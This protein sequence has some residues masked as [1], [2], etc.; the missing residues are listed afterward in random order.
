MEELSELGLS[1]GQ[2][3]DGKLFRGGGCALCFGSG[4][5]GRRG[6][7]ELMPMFTRLKAQVVKSADAQELRKM[8]RSYQMVSL[9]EEGRKLAT[10]GLTTASEVLRV[11]R[12]GEEAMVEE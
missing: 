8:A 1:K 10:H 4:Y 6:I 5:K 2:L 7:Y 11:T 9:F 12:M 3:S